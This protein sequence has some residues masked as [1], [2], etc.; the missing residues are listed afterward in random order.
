MNKLTKIEKKLLT[1]KDINIDIGDTVKVMVRV[2]EGNKEREQAFQGL[3]IKHR[4]SGAGEM[5]TV[6]KISS[7]IGVERIFPIH[8]PNLKSVKVL[9]KGKI[10][11]AKLYY[12][13]DRIGKAAR[14]TERREEPKK[15]S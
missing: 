7:G 12:L 1:D 4:G 11:R 5:F 8:S 2:I 3:V 15:K 13:R 6:R 10:R 14:I 9:R